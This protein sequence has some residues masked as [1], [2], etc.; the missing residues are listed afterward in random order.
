MYGTHQCDNQSFI[1]DKFGQSF[2]DIEPSLE[3][4]DGVSTFSQL[5]FLFSFS[6]EA[7]KK[8]LVLLSTKVGDGKDRQFINKQ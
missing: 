6:H 7:R 3:T 8:H 5:A 1:E 4:L 2:Q